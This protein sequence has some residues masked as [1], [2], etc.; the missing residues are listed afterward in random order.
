VP[1]IGFR[2][3]KL[4][5]QSAPDLEGPPTLGAVV[6]KAQAPGGVDPAA[7]A[8]DL[9]KAN[10]AMRSLLQRTGTALGAIATA[11]MTGLGWARLNDVFPIPRNA[12]TWT[13]MALVAALLAALGG[14]AWLAS[15][16]FYAQ[17]RIMIGTTTHSRAPMNNEDT[18]TVD[19]ILTENARP[20]EAPGIRDVELRALRFERIARALRSLDDKA[21]SALQAESDRLYGVV[22]MTLHQAA[23]VVLEHRSRRA[24]SR[25][26]T[27][28]ALALAAV[29]IILSF[30][31]ADYYKGERDLSASRVTCGKGEKSFPSACAPFETSAARAKRHNEQKA[32]EAA[33]RV[34][35]A[36]SIDATKRTLAQKRLLKAAGDCQKSIPASVSGPTRAKAVALCAV[37]AAK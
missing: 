29:G 4:L 3:L 23:T 36:R 14:S 9:A 28:L 7:D 24:F 19:R 16:F 12:E 25:W 17:R 1:E 8:A 2:V 31:I 30:A 37:A 34:T 20:E 32:T 13:W 27:F 5:L 15:I 18:E 35:K 11:I 22:R 6:P 10:E 26:P 21:A 33:N